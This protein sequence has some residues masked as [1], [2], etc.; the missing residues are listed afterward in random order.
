VLVVALL[1]AAPATAHGPALVVRDPLG[2]ARG[3]AADIHTLSIWNDDDS[4]V[5]RLAL[6]DRRSLTD[7]DLVALVL[8]ADADRETG[9]RLFERDGVDLVL[10]VG[11]ANATLVDL[12]G[13]ITQLEPPAW[14]SDGVVTVAL[15]RAD[16]GGTRKLAV[17]AVTSLRSD[18][19]SGDETG[20]ARFV[21]SEP[22]VIGSSVALDAVQGAVTAGTRVTARVAVRLDDGATV[23]PS[24]STCRMTFA[25]AAVKR[26]APCSWRLPRAARGKRVVITARGTYR[27]VAFATT[28]RVVRV[29]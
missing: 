14:T 25:H 18:A 29:R 8:D 22:K 11:E 27:G 13:L 19:D 26:L 24:T 15:A 1:A 6:A 28:P 16:L 12:G 9:F 3:G 17:A 2:D 20:F 10:L 4:I 21:V 23:S 7:D 5:F